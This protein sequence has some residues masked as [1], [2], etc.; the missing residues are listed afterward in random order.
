MTDSTIKLLL[1]FPMRKL[2]FEKGE[3]GQKN[4]DQ[5]CNQIP[6]P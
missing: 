4:G 3:K 1:S 5:S 6:G 2:I